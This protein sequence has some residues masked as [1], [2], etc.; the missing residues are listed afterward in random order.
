MLVL[1]RIAGQSVVT[2]SLLA[3]P[4]VP[5]ARPQVP[6]V[7]GAWKVDSYTLKRDGERL[8]IILPSGSV[9]SASTLNPGTLC[10]RRLSY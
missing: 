5:D 6:G 4:W 7:R 3:G 8:T 10:S 1:K 2:L 9:A